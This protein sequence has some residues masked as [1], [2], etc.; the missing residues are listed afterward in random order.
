[1]CLGTTACSRYQVKTSV[2]IGCNGD[3]TTELQGA[4]NATG[5]VVWEISTFDVTLCH[6]GLLIDR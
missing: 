1:M 2:D 6:L 3:A 5:D 4:Q